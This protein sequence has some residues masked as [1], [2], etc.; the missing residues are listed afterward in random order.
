MFTPCP[1][2]KNVTDKNWGHRP[3][4][5]RNWGGA[6]ATFRPKEG[7]V[8]RFVTVRRP[9]M[10]PKTRWRKK[11]AGRGCTFVQSL[12]IFLY[13]CH[14]S[15]QI[16]VVQ[17]FSTPELL[18]HLT[19]RAAEIQHSRPNPGF[20]PWSWLDPLVH[21]NKHTET[22]AFLTTRIN[23]S[24]KGTFLECVSCF[25]HTVKAVCDAMTF[26][27]N[28]QWPLTCFRLAP[29]GSA[30]KSA[31][32]CRISWMW[33]TAIKLKKQAQRNIF[34]IKLLFCRHRCEQFEFRCFLSSCGV[35]G[36]IMTSHSG[37]VLICG[38]MFSTHWHTAPQTPCTSAWPPGFNV[39]LQR[40]HFRQNL[41]QSLPKDETF[42][43]AEEEK[44]E[45]SGMYNNSWAAAIKYAQIKQ[46]FIK[47]LPKETNS[48]FYLFRDKVKMAL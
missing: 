23:N 35:I 43:A 28:S 8:A 47:L 26:R 46:L 38:Y 14:H 11:L 3:M 27:I 48:V 7:G 36:A 31:S 10:L 25:T 44:R 34:L 18:W 15:S 39:L 29:T 2:R 24:Q 45:K 5:E 22:V 32:C 21:R 1:R 33:L 42:S 12:W 17:H 16:W 40:S 19:P 20:I 30:P 4:T 41:C 9:V 37:G 6:S 13:K